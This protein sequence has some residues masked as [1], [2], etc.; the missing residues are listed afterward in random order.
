MTETEGVR[1]KERERERDNEMVSERD[2]EMVSDRENRTERSQT[3]IRKKL[4]R[5]TVQVYIQEK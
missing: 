3:K 2:N 1:E 5:I 4:L